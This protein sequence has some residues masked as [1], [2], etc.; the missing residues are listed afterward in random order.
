MH[1]IVFSQLPT[2]SFEDLTAKVLVKTMDTA[3]PNAERLEFGIVYKTPEGQVTWVGWWDAFFF[4]GQEEG[5][6]LRCFVQV[7]F[8]G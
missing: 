1:H 6:Y 5:W 4:G 7:G 8:N 2:V 3:T